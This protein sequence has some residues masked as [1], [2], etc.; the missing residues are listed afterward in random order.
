[1]PYRIFNVKPIYM[2]IINLNPIFNII[3]TFNS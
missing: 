2:I 3:L 1:M